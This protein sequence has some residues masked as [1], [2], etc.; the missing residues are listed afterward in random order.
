MFEQ[1]ENDEI[2]LDRFRNYYN[3]EE[4]KDIIDYYLTHNVQPNVTQYSVQ[5]APFLNG[6]F[7]EKSPVLYETGDFLEIKYKI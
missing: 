2:Y 1:F 3:P 5:I 4:L 7:L 6:A